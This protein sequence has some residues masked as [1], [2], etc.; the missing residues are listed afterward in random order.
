MRWLCLDENFTTIT[1]IDCISGPK[2]LMSDSGTNDSFSFFSKQ[3][4]L[5]YDIQCSGRDCLYEMIAELLSNGSSVRMCTATFP[6]VCYVSVIPWELNGIS[7]SYP[8]DKSITTFRVVWW[9]VLILFK[10]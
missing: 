3:Q 7:N 1:K 2:A 6:E 10:L 8:L 9:Y 5:C 4:V